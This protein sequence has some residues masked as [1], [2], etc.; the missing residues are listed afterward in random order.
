MKLGILCT[1]INGFGRKGFYNTQEIGLGRALVHKGHTVTVYKC[2]RKDKKG[3]RPE[4]NEIEPG[5]T[6]LYLPAGG[7]GAHGM[8]RTG[9]LDKEMDGLLC[10]SDN[11]VFLP[12]IFRFCEKN[13]IRF[14]PYIGTTFSLHKGLH[15]KVM[16]AWFA[17]GT[18]KIYKK[19]PVIAK[20]EG[21]KREL[22]ALGVKDIRIAPV[23]LDTDVLKKDFKRYD[24][25]RLRAEYGFERDDVLLCNVSRMDPEKR[26]LDMIEIFRRIRG[27]KKFRLLLVGEG[28]LSGEVREKIARYGLSD[29][30]RLSDRIPYKDMWKIYAMS[31]YFINLS[32]SEIFG[33]A[34][35]EAV[36]YET[37]VTAFQG[38]PGPSMTLKG[39]AGHHLCADDADVEAWLT[40]PYPRRE[41]LEES[42]GKMIRDFS[43]DRCADRFVEIIKK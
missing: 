32:K 35:M 21:A 7:L 27:K 13:G 43:W 39:M 40:A 14:V 8:L 15:A 16:D 12:H 10:F 23:G 3:M 2:L 4:R 20:T 33:M 17:A 25:D 1:M 42:A 30:I 24:R 28:P 9:I 18:L 38:T 41:D 6:V 36:Y 11:Q 5:L 37:S 19:N 26:P 22:E 31:D 34:I 29:E